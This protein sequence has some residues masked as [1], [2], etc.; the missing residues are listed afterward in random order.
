VTNII[1]LISIIIVLIAKKSDGRTL[2][3]YESLRKYADRLPAAK[4]APPRQRKPPRDRS[5]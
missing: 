3:V 5:P 1:V 4:V 2:V